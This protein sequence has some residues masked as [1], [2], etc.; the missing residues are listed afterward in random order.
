MCFVIFV[1]L[2]FREFWSKIR[3]DRLKF[4]SID[5]FI[6]SVMSQRFTLCVPLMPAVAVTGS[7]HKWELKYILPVY[8][9]GALHLCY[10]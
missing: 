5:V 8:N 1:I 3:R 7:I 4:M 2:H 9:V 10:W 6:D